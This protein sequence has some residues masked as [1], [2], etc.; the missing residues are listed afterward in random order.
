[1]IPLQAPRPIARKPVRSQR[2]ASVS[3]SP[4]SRKVRLSPP[5]SAS[6]FEPFSLSSSRQAAEDSAGPDTVPERLSL[7]HRHRDRMERELRD[8]QLALA[9]VD[10]KIRTYGGETGPSKIII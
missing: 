1:M 9:V 10:Y 8:R 5:G 2:P 4:I 3:S 7:L 6:G